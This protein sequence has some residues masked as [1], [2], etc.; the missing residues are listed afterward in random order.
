MKIEVKEIFES[1]NWE[2]WLK[3]VEVK[4]VEVKKCES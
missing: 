3:V 1:R 2:S 4:V